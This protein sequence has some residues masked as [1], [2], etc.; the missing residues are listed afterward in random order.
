M[1]P[2]LLFRAGALALACA[3]TASASY[4]LAPDDDYSGPNFFDGFTFSTV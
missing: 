3:S 4:I 2:S 1:S